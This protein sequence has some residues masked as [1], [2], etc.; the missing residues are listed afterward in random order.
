M[1]NFTASL[2]SDGERIIV[3]RRQHWLVLVDRSK[4][5][6]LGLVVALLIF[7]LRGS[8]GSDGIGGGLNFVLGWVVLAL[9]VYAVVIFAYQYLHW[10]NDS[11]IVT[12]RRVI[13]VPGI[14]NKK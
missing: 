1:A 8:L 5:A 9:V 11:F 12:N 6:I 3:Q 7:I 2:M 13:Q 10:V 4:L 14:L